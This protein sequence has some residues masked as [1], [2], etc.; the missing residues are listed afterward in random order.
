VFTGNFR[1]FSVAPVDDDVVAVTFERPEKKNGLTYDMKRDLIEVLQQIQMDPQ[2]AVVIFKGEGDSFCAGDDITGREPEYDESLGLAP[3]INHGGFDHEGVYGRLRTWSQPLTLAVRELDKLTI[4]SLQGFV[5]QSGLTVALACDMRVARASARL[6]S[7]TLRF[8]FLPDE[9]GHA[10]LTQYL[11]APRALAFLLRKE[12]VTG[13][14]AYELGLV[15]EIVESQDDLEA[16]TIEL[17]KELASLPR[18]A[19]R[20][21]KHATYAAAETSLATAM[22]DIALRTVVADHL[23]AAREGRHDFVEKRKPNFGTSEGQK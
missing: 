13:R 3:P 12:I 23:P 20:M 8:G 10:L 9:G 7:A 4:A 2:P 11:G 18:F 15:T 6:G 1:G 22:R 17:A 21:V 5:I 19:A 14:E 16:R